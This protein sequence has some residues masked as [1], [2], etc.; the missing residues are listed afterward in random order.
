M[1]PPPHR[2]IYLRFEMNLMAIGFSELD[3]LQSRLEQRREEV[4]ADQARRAA[5]RAPDADAARFSPNAL[6]GALRTVR[7]RAARA[8]RPLNSWTRR[9][10]T[11]EQFWLPWVRYWHRYCTLTDWIFH[12]ANPLRLPDVG[13]DLL[14]AIQGLITDGRTATFAKQDWFAA[15]CGSKNSPIEAHPRPA[16]ATIDLY[17]NGAVRRIYRWSDGRIR[18]LRR[19][20]AGISLSLCQRLLR[21]LEAIGII[22]CTRRNHHNQYW[23]PAKPPAIPDY[24]IAP[25]LATL[26]ALNGAAHRRA[27]ELSQS[28]A[29]ARFRL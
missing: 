3:A 11:R 23:I 16:D 8:C 14:N 21:L 9:G 4:R 20:A 28:E 13:R 6:A 10:I 26:A 17:E 18:L 5:R 12:A 15:Q 22:G 1:S 19:S 2:W 7:E 29:R 25:E 27:T 24:E